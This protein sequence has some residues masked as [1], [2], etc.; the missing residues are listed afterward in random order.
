MFCP[1]LTPIFGYAATH[2]GAAFEQP[3]VGPH[4]RSFVDLIGKWRKG[5]ELY[6]A[7]DGYELLGRIPSAT[8]EGI[9]FNYEH[10]DFN[11]A[12]NAII[13]GAH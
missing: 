7:P 10:A 5:R 9:A 4:A 2:A 11:E 13:L 1:A 12:V 3:E 8:S 6:L